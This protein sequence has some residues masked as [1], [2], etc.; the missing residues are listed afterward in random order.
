MNKITIFLVITMAFL[1]SCAANSNDDK[2]YTLAAKL[3]KLSAAVESTVRYKN[4]PR[5]IQD[6]ELII[7]STAHDPSLAAPFLN[8]TIHTKTNN[9]SAIIL[10]CTEDGQNRLLEDAVCTSKLDKHHWRDS[11]MSNNCQFTIEISEVCSN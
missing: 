4:P 10:I 8:Y 5:N 11:S 9:K 6:R 2:Y 7:I 1:S 3:T